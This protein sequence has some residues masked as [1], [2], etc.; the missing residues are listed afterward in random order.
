MTRRRKSQVAT[1]NMTEERLQFIGGQFLTSLAQLAQL[2][3]SPL[4]VLVNTHGMDGVELTTDLTDTLMQWYDTL[5]TKQRVK[6]WTLIVDFYMLPTPH[7]MPSRVSN[8]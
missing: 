5:D 8:S 1:S 6:F 2:P 7:G 3:K 4:S